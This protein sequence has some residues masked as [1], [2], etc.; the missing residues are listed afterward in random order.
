MHYDELR[1]LPKAE[2]K[3]PMP[4]VRPPREETPSQTFKAKLSTH[5]YFGEVALIRELEIDSRVETKKG[6]VYLVEN[7][8]VLPA[9]Q[10]W[11]AWR[12]RP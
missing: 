3:T 5:V 9:W 8:D 6:D 11:L 10:K 12:Y 2:T 4:E 7:K 1:G